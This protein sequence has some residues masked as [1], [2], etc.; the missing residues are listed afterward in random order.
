MKKYTFILLLLSFSFNIQAQFSSYSPALG[1]EDHKNLYGLNHTD[2]VI[3]LGTYA[4]PASTYFQTHSNHPLYFGNNN[5][6]TPKVV[7]TS[8]GYLGINLAD[9]VMPAEKLEIKNGSIALYGW[10][11]PSKP[12]GI[13]FTNNAGSTASAFLG[14][15]DAQTFGFR[16]YTTGLNEIVFKTVSGSARVGLGNTNPTSA[17]DV[18]GTIR[19]NALAG[20]ERG[21]VMV[22]T[23][24]TLRRFSDQPLTSVAPTDYTF[25]DMGMLN[26]S[27]VGYDASPT[28]GTWSPFGMYH[29]IEK[30]LQLV[31]GSTIKNLTA[32]FLDNNGS[33]KMQACLR[34]SDNSNGVATIYCVNSSTDNATIQP[35]TL[36]ADISEVVNNN[37]YSYIL[38]VES[39]TNALG[40]GPWNSSMGVSGVKFKIGY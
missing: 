6:A 35:Y 27:D 29:F 11:S 7:L 32:Y 17:L 8:P 19:L 18:N 34:I 16:S 26:D 25:S 39:V 12:T 9:G 33:G 36:A 13:V 21:L 14:M 1:Y 4:L 24:G 5:S 28:F 22:K 37:A 30:S 20:S 10:E 31:Q 38:R 15:L 40:S 3:S 2:G 23:D